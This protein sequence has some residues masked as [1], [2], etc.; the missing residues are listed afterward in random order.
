[1]RTVRM[2]ALS[3]VAAAVVLMAAAPPPESPP[4]GSPAGVSAGA[5]AGVSAGDDGPQ[6][7]V[8]AAV[9]GS[10]KDAVRRIVLAAYSRATG[11]EL[12]DAPWDGSAAAL[13]S[14]QVAHG[15]DLVLVNGPQLAAGCHAQMFARIDWGVVGRDRFVPQAT[16][17]CG[18]GAWLSATV[19][20]WDRDKLP[21]GGAAPNWG[22]FWDV[23][24]HPG[25]RG[26]H[27]AARGNLEIALLA[28]GVAAGDV[29]RVLRSA[30]G[31]DRAYRK[32]DQLKP[33]V[34]WWDQPG[35]PAQLIASAKVLLI[36]AP[37]A[38]L[39][40][41]PKSHVGVQWT[42]SLAEVESWAILAGAPHGRAVL[43]ALLVASDPARQAE[44][45]RATGLGVTVRAA[46]ALLPLDARA[47]NP[48]TPAN[49][50][51]GLAIDEGFWAEHGEALEAR[52]SAWVG[53]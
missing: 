41:G 26:L 49:L 20:A 43:A 14:L 17:D 35:Q 33:Y 48:G 42:G 11:T 3:L 4:A 18:A 50:T 46:T 2:R 44:F 6:P 5:S 51:A 34:V 23:A 12:G 21:L 25:R 10:A 22:D 36:S 31:V 40:W 9:P 28:D 37:S 39:P 45:A 15:A 1:M 27:R 16:G 13:Q 52:F 32:L 8:V 7:L 30:D 24:R 29:Y 38:A 53:R 47:Q 19:L